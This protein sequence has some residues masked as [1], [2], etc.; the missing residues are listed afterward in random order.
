MAIVCIQ[1]KRGLS[2][3]WI[4]QNPVLAVGEPGFEKDTGR[5]K[6]G[7]GFSPW[8]DLNYVGEDETG[9]YNAAT[10]LDFPS[11]GKS[12]VIYKA[13]D[14]Q[15]IYQWNDELG[16]Y[17][18]LTDLSQYATLAYVQELIDNLPEGNQDMIA[19]THEEILE[20]CR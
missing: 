6:I 18:L 3:S 7:D 2:T 20:I 11:V 15:K 10:H 19:L 17:E 4:T 9:I 13:Q 8:L 1:L 14:E 5:L 16:C 12:N